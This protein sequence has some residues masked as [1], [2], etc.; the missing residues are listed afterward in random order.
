MW[1]FFWCCTESQLIFLNIQFLLYCVAR[2]R[3]QSGSCGVECVK[4]DLTLSD[5]RRW[6]INSVSIIQMRQNN[7]IIQHFKSING[8]NSTDWS[9]NSNLGR[10]VKDHNH[11]LRLCSCHS[12]LIYIMYI[13][14]LKIFRL[15]HLSG[16]EGLSSY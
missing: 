11:Q 5:L 8:Y 6:T 10:D 15:K 7:G 12:K 1:K 13:V 4:S 16:V 2:A 3:S 9:K 14:S